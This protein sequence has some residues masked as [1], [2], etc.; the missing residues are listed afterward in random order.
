MLLISFLLV[1][2]G[3]GEKAGFTFTS[4]TTINYRREPWETGVKFKQVGYTL[5]ATSM[6]TFQ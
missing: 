3:N 1:K 4:S 6:L 5:T 2:Q